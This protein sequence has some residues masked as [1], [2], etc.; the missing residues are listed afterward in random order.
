MSYKI[1]V[2]DDEEPVRELFRDLL[3]DEDWQTVCVAGGEEALEVIKKEDFDLVLLDIK[4]TGM[5]GFDVLKKIK[6]I[7]PSLE[8][9]MLTGFGYVE[10]LVDL[11]EQCGSCGYISK[12]LPV[13]QIMDNIKVFAKAA[14]E[15]KRKAV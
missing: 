3:H 13:A 10:E 15:K 9:A 8:V 5:N 12:N 2:I 14:R 7:K 6:E 1:L 4:L 11:A